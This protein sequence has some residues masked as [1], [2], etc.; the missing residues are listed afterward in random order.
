[1][2]K[3]VFK[4]KKF[5]V[6]VFIFAIVASAYANNERKMP[7]KYYSYEVTEEFVTDENLRYVKL[8]ADI[9]SD[10]ELDNLIVQLKHQKEEWFEDHDIL[11][12]EIEKDSGRSYVSVRNGEMRVDYN[13]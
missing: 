2:I 11:Y 7:T 8:E 4:K 13:Y 3:W 9:D 10:K 6:A 5:W 12:I 1:M